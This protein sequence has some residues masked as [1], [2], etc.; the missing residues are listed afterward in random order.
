MDPTSIFLS[1]TQD[2][3]KQN[4]YHALES[5]NPYQMSGQ[6]MFATMQQQQVPRAGSFNLNNISND[7]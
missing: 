4:K 6:S 5:M 1:N 7:G 3:Y 2:H